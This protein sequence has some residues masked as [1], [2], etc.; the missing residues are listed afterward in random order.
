MSHMRIV[1]TVITTAIRVFFRRLFRGAKHPEWSLVF[2]ITAETSRTMF[3]HAPG[4][5][6]APSGGND[7]LRRL[8][9]PIPL[10]V[11]RRCQLER[12]TLAGRPSEVHT[13][14]TFRAGQDATLLYFHGGGYV[15]CSPRS[16]RALLSRLAIASRA[17]VV[18]IDYSKAPE[19]PFPAAI[20]ECVASYRELL[21]EGCDPGRMA[22]GG[23]SAGGGLA[24]A[25]LQRLRNESVA[26]PACTLLLSPWVDLE[27]LG[28][29]IQHN[30][31]YDYLQAGALGGAVD[32]YLA[33]HDRRD[34]LASA[35]HADFRGLPP[36]L[37]M[38]GSAE[39]FCSENM[40]LVERARAAGIEVEHLLESGMIHVYPLFADIEPRARVAIYQAGQFIKQRC[41]ASSVD[42]SKL[43]SA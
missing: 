24:L 31:P 32:L 22:L 36:L 7:P 26:M 19:H 20:D 1:L 3:G 23:D 40:L 21:A 42:G 41:M 11:A 43:E 27:S 4:Q 18:A 2:E 34:P 29:T 14:R 35:I 13:P 25:V 15:T 5:K 12:R 8:A 6:G 10:S 17:R 33:G 37:V 38:T 16:H 28:E 9:A 30:G 39:L